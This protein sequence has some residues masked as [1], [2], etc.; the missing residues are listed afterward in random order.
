MTT[1]TTMTTPQAPTSSPDPRDRRGPIAIVFGLGCVIVA[2]AIMIGIALTHPSIPATRDHW[3]ESL[4]WDQELER[5]AHSRAL[6]WTI[7]TLERERDALALE[8][9][10][11]QGRPLA[12]LQGSVTLRRADTGA[13]DRTLALVEIG[14]GRYRSAESIPAAGLVELHVELHDAG[15]DAFGEQRWLEL[16][17]FEEPSR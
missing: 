17:S 8:V 14:S 3:A 11:A 12:G 1:T 9:H 15:G 13:D 7:A 6:G 4:A 2:N 5:R 16:S 10:D